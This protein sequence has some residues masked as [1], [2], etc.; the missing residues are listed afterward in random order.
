MTTRL[1]GETQTWEQRLQQLLPLFG[2]R[3]WIVVADSAYPAQS[4]PG[5]ETIFTGED[6]LRLLGKVLYAVA[7]QPHVR[8]N[9]YID[10]ELMHVPEKD[11][12]G[13][14]E[15]RGE[16]ESLVG[17][18]ARSLDHE[19]IIA[20]LDESAKLF[21]IVILKSTLAIPYTSVFLQLDCGYWNQDAE[22]RLRNAIANKPAATSG[23]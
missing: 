8:A 15:L 12:P 20:R 7:A 10:A 11:A 17:Q 9:V 4:N 13:V 22:E 19:Q 6:H 14:T 21:N 2:H 16:I 18:K 23:S 1:E 3:N 5:I